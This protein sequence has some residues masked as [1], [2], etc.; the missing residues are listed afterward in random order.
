MSIIND[1]KEAIA[2]GEIEADAPPGV[3]VHEITWFT[4]P[5]I[6]TASMKIDKLSI[7]ACYFNLPK[8]K[9][10]H[11]IGSVITLELPTTGGAIPNIKRFMKIIS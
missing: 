6:V 4:G 3:G 7:K 5:W 8:T 10:D 1:I 11:Q 2:S 9:D